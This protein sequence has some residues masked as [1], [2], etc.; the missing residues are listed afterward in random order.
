MSS[1]A[2]EAVK[3][4]IDSDPRKHGLTVP[5]TKFTVESPASLSRHSPGGVLISAV[6][7]R[8][9]IER[10][11]RRRGYSGRIILTEVEKRAGAC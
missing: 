7:Y 5:G 8:P 4:V 10:E 1:V 2:R 6:T 3:A 9:A 11:L